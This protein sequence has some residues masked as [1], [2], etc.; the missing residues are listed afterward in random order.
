MSLFRLVKNLIWKHI[1]KLLLIF[2]KILLYFYDIFLKQTTVSKS[3]QLYILKLICLFS[4]YVIYYKEI[5]RFNNYYDNYVQVK[6]YTSNS[7]KLNFSIFQFYNSCF[8]LT[9]LL[10]SV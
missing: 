3:F 1:I 5:H 6:A 8:Y 4:N 10:I 7:I 9:N 2:P